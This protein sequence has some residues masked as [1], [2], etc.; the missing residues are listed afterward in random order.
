MLIRHG[1]RH[2]GEGERDRQRRIGRQRCAYQLDRRRIH[3][4]KFM[5]MLMSI[6]RYLSKPS[7]ILYIHDSFF[8]LKVFYLAVLAVGIWAG[9][10][11]RRAARDA[12]RDL[13]NQGS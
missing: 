11:Q 4:R 2:S 6:G 10:K 13:G 9:W 5:F 3:R 8:G 7:E 12:G 1:G